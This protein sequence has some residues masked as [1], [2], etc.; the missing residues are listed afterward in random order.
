MRAGTILLLVGA[1]GESYIAS[2]AITLLAPWIRSRKPGCP[3]A[4][5]NDGF[6][7]YCYD[8]KAMKSMDSRKNES[9]LEKAG[10]K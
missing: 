4:A 9:V 2:G 3:S 10:S 7:V 5:K 1:L 6:E 8:L